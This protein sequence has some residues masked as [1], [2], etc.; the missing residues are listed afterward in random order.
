[1]TSKHA[2]MHEAAKVGVVLGTSPTFLQQTHLQVTSPLK[3]P[4]SRASFCPSECVVHA[5]LSWFSTQIW[6]ELRTLIERI[7][8]Y[9][10]C[11][12]WTTQR[13]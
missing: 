11:T 9:R 4:P 8:A 5:L 7:G 10:L 6:A 12:P 13:Q 3:S 2:H 1:M